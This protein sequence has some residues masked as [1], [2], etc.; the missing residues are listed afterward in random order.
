MSI[1]LS[2]VDGLCYKLVSELDYECT[3]TFSMCDQEKTSLT[4]VQ[5]SPLT[6]CNTAARHSFSCRG[7]YRSA[8]K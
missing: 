1:T 6:G 7:K 3:V 2:P 4:C 8:R 5:K